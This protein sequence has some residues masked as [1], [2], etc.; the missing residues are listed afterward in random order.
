MNYTTY[1][2]KLTAKEAE[3]MFAAITLHR[4][5]YDGFTAEEIE[6]WQVGG[7]LSALKR[8]ERKLDRLVE[9]AGN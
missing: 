9:K 2:L 3:A 6:D 8:V 5:S 1:E 4:A 7:E